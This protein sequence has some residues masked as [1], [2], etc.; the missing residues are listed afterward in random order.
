MVERAAGESKVERMS[1][2]S[3]HVGISGSAGI[4][5]DTVKLKVERKAAR[6]RDPNTSSRVSATGVAAGAIDPTPAGTR[7]S[8]VREQQRERRPGRSARR[9]R[10][11]GAGML[12]M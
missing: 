7:R 9:R 2:D 6:R 3:S 4:R 8:M 11:N 12:W 10:R 5:K 1:G